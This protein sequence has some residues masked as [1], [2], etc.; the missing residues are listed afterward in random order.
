MQINAN[1]SPLQSQ[2]VKN[3]SGGILDQNAQSNQTM[4]HDQYLDNLIEDYPHTHK[5]VES[6]RPGPGHQP[7]RHDRSKIQQ[8]AYGALNQS[9]SIAQVQ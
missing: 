5:M 4:T 1:L 2:G 7:E 6:I 9:V 8:A 3:R